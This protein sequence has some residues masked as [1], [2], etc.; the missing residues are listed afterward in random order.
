MTSLKETKRIDLNA[1]YFGIDTI[2]LMENAGRNV[3]EECVKRNFERIAIFCGTGNNGGDGLVAAR[4]LLSYGKDVLI[5][6]TV[7]ERTEENKKNFEILKNF[8]INPIIKFIRDSKDI[9]K[10]EKEIEKFKPDCV[11]DALLGVGVKGEIREPI[12]SIVK[13]LNELKCYKISVDVPTGDENLKFKPDLVISFETKK[14]ENKNFTEIVKGIGIP[15]SIK[16]LCGIGDVIYALKEYSG[17]EHKGYFGKVLVIGGS[18]DYI[19]AVYLTAK[20]A[21]KLVD[22]VYIATP[23]FVQSRIFDPTLIF[24]PVEDEFYLKS[25]I[26]DLEK[27]DCIV[28]GNGISMNSDKNFVEDV[29]KRGK[30]VVIDADAL[31]LIDSEILDKKTIVTPHEGEFKFLFKTEIPD[32]FDEKIEIVKNLSEKYRTTIVLKGKY[33]IIASNGNFKINKTGNIRMTVGGT[34]DVLAG[35]IAGFYAQCEN[36]FDSA[37]AGTF[38]NGFAGDLVFKENPYFD[39]LDLIEKIPYALKICKEF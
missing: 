38:L 31:K 34:G 23:K 24:I 37:C 22:L 2:L 36:P 32:K 28:I 26:N 14:E 15:K 11:I 1:K 16:N 29:I 20:S 10:I 3:A 17:Y 33:D 13:F 25:K 27:F 6:S 4:I 8:E 35:L 12:K 21:Q 9:E 30:K 18:R 5:F 19:G 39:A 7:G